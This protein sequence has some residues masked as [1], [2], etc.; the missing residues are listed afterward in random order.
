MR[1]KTIFLSLIFTLALLLIPTVMILNDD[2]NVSATTSTTL[3][4][5]EDATSATMTYVSHGTFTSGSSTR[6]YV[7]WQLD[8]SVPKGHNWGAYFYLYDLKT[9]MIS[10]GLDSSYTDNCI[11]VL[12]DSNFTGNHNTAIIQS[13]T[14]ISYTHINALPGNT[15]KVAIGP[16]VS[17]AIN[18][19]GD[20]VFSNEYTSDYQNTRWYFTSMNTL[21]D[22]L[23]M[24][25]IT[26]AVH[27]PAD[28]YTVTLN[29]N[30]G[31]VSPNNITVT[32]GQQYGTIPTPTRTGYTFGG[33]YT[34][35]TGGTE[36]TST[37][38]CS[39]NSDH[40]IYAHW[41]EGVEIYP[42]G[43]TT[44]AI[45]KYVNKGTYT[46]GSSTYQYV[47][48]QLDVTVPRQ[49]NWEADIY[50]QYMSSISSS[51]GI[52]P[53]YYTRIGND[54]S[55]QNNQAI[56]QSGTT[57]NYRLVGGSYTLIRL[58]G[59]NAISTAGDTVYPNQYSDDFAS[60]KWVVVT[61]NSN[62]TQTVR[63]FIS[64]VVHVPSNVF[65]VTFNPNGGTVSPNSMVI[66]YGDTYGALPTPT[67]SG[68]TFVGWFTQP[69]GG[70]EITST[71]TYTVLACTM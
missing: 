29:P 12:N 46:S 2:S 23:V 41:V 66:T 45:L 6:Q 17:N 61:G 34:S 51:F 25:F 9:L 5:T 7:N 47:N 52:D 59:N 55:P 13:G 26:I 16:N 39:T 10:A 11:S 57:V 37:T 24:H 69:S 8:I 53:T 21:Y 50:L 30:G 58:A 28:V 20:T 60:T 44:S 14:I 18:S 67:R 64:I 4:P 49:H 54:V 48:W 35:S 68:Y 62:W 56:S 42:T 27:I 33:W 15:N 43:D 65:T 63:N 31:T 70:S 32:Y 40:T 36:V 1:C 38:V 71:S 19:S 3:T 22:P